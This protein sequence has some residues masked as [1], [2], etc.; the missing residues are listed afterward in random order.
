MQK[1]ILFVFISLTSF[2]FAPTTNINAQTTYVSGI[3]TDSLTNEPMPFVTVYF[4]GTQ[5]LQMTDEAGSFSIKTKSDA[6][7]LIISSVGY[8]DYIFPVERGEKYQITAK[9]QN[10]E[11]AMEEVVVKPKRERYKRRGN[12][13]VDFVKKVIK[14][15]EKNSI[16]ENDY[17][18]YD[19]YD[20]LTIA[21]NDFNESKKDKPIFR[22]FKFLFD[23]VDTSEV[24]GKPILTVSI[25]ERNSKIYYRKSSNSKKQYIEAIRRTGIDDMLN[26]ESM[27]Q[28]YDELFKEVNIYDNQ[29]NLMLT[30]FVSPLSNIAT[31]FYKY[32]L[33]DTLVIDGDSCVD[34]GFAPH[35]S[36]SN[37]FVGHMYVTLDSTFFVKKVDMNVPK[38]INL[39]Y[40]E[41]M[42][43]KQEFERS[44]KGL[45]IKKRDDA[46]VELELIPG[47]QG[48]YV[49]RIIGSDNYS[50][51]AP[52]DLSIFN[53][54]GSVIEDEYA[55]MQPKQ[56]WD[57]NR[58]I[59]IKKKENSVDK[60]LTQL[61]ENKVFYWSEKILTSLVSG[62]V[63]TS[64]NSKFD[65]GP[66]NTTISGNTVEGARLRLGGMT[67]PNLH[68]RI[69]LDTYV[70][71]GTRDGRFKYKGDFIYS[72]I[73]KKEHYKEYPIHQI[74]LTHKYDINQLGQQ[75]RF[76]NKDNVFL[77]LKR[78]EDVRSTYL[79]TS[80]IEYM[81]E[82]RHGLS[83][84]IGFA[85]KTEE[86]TKWVE[87]IDGYGNSF[88]R[89]NQ[90][91]FNFKIR[92]AHKERFYQTKGNRYPISKTAPIFLINH[93][94]GWRGFL[95][96]H[97][98]Y[99]RTD[100]N[101]QKAFWFS[102]FGHLNTVINLSKVWTKTPY[103]ALIIP[104]ANLTY[105]I[106]PQSFALL[107]PIEFIFDNYAAWDLEYYANGILFN[108]IPG[109]RYLKI[110][111]VVSFRG[112]F[113]YLSD[114]NNPDIDPSL[115]RFPNVNQNSRW[116][117]KLPYMEV[118]VGLDNIL[119]ILRIEYVFRVTYRDLP[120]IKKGGVR[121]ELHFS[122]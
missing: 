12:P 90:A 117:P 16:E 122:F 97:Y 46:I 96:S 58:M 81:R 31:S 66:L 52:A 51:E 110:R 41:S 36:E 68:K 116:K 28:F 89:Y 121:I 33:L 22:K 118:G 91:D 54:E 61:R 48:L 77:A 98:N 93:G 102:T 35:N 13:A 73:D 63:P 7:E 26:Q 88:N 40:V 112:F 78:M 38:D 71:Y 27:Q 99:Q 104:D 103:T 8:K 83:Y 64:K 120:E 109:I 59:P 44:D 47:T 76:T 62:Y 43:I 69:F 114:K 67:T 21:F 49:R 50:F 106:Q 4:R 95:D 19:Q 55:L 25:K 3:V 34:L 119:S 17:Y 94:M 75:Y 74:R 70:A 20:R 39:N 53:K 24:S 2:L 111:E 107:N 6:K 85:Y 30:R 42:K 56:Y 10:A 80:E 82:H 100:I 45:R 9:L 105:T 14:A 1:Y 32:Y 86:A 79:R 11:Y 113:G 37:G 101:F 57:D 23:F 87:F 60:I 115:W 18:T 92:Y 108:H 15:G 5:T 84:N 72:F 65:L 29:I